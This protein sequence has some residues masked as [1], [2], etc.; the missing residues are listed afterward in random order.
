MSARRPRV[1][2]FP[3]AR[4]EK[5]ERAELELMQRAGGPDLDAIQRTASRISKA[6]GLGAAE[7]RL[8][9][10]RAL[11]IEDLGRTFPGAWRFAV[12]CD[13]ALDRRG[14][15]A[16]DPRL[17]ARIWER[18]DR[19]GA[20]SGKGLG[21]SG[22]VAWALAWGLEDCAAEDARFD[23]WRFAGIAESADQLGRMCLENEYLL[24]SWLDIALGAEKVF[25]VWLEPDSSVQRK[26]ARGSRDRRL[27]G[28]LRELDMS[29]R[30]GS[31][32]LPAAQVAAL[33]P[34]DVLVLADSLP[35]G[36]ISLC[37]TDLEIFGRLERAGVLRIEGARQIQV[38]GGEDMVIRSQDFEGS[39]AGGIDPSALIV[40]LTA[41]AGRI[42][43]PIGQ[44]CDLRAG[45]VLTLPEPVLGP[46]LLRCEGRTLARGELVDVEGRRGVRVMEC[47]SDPAELAAEGASR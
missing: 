30:L 2:S 6:L 38:Q 16:L 15:I 40:N 21:G 47:L 20:R 34:G 31:V 5:V 8:G 3:A 1:M 44:L 27:P 36:Q 29:F 9:R 26:R 42:R 43:I 7:M 18:V 11:R 19:R 46:V 41:E 39:D 10:V 12:L 17:L 24:S 33:A 32:S 37:R 45:D 35:E 22:V 4:L 14:F 28:W 23:P 25:A 13:P